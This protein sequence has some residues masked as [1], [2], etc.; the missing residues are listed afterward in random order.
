[1]KTIIQLAFCLCL[2]VYTATGQN[3]FEI[4]GGANTHHMWGGVQEG[5]TAELNYGTGYQIGISFNNY[6][7]GGI[8]S[9]FSLMYSKQSASSM[10]ENFSNADYSGTSTLDWEKESVHLAVYPFTFFVQRLFINFG[11]EGSLTMNS[12]TT[13]TYT[14]SGFTGVVV[15]DIVGP[16]NVLVEPTEFNYG[17]LARFAYPVPVRQSLNITPQYISYLGINKE[18]QTPDGL[19]FRSFRNQLAIA[20]E[21][22]F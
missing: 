20:L 6:T 2:C 21:F 22:L 11:L 4:F 8:L 19:E 16:E 10:T 5:Q 12:N 15:K 7:T 17:V 13:G 1:M 9:K 14:H 3:S 18:Y